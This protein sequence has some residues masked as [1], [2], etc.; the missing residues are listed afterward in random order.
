MVEVVYV[1]LVRQSAITFEF[2]P[3][4]I[5]FFK[6]FWV[7]ELRGVIV[8]LGM[9]GN[10]KSFIVIFKWLLVF[11]YWEIYSF[12]RYRR[13]CDVFARVKILILNLVIQY[14]KSALCKSFRDALF[15]QIFRLTANFSCFQNR[16]AL[17][18][19]KTFRRS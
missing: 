6:H 1:L 17:F 12:L 13:S 7:L 16:V 15:I 9:I 10:F 19:D 14:F 8:Y 3:T 5:T 18:D 2:F 11:E 4:A